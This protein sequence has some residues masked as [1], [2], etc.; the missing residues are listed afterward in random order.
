ME[1]ASIGQILRQEEASAGQHHRLLTAADPNNQPKPQQPTHRGTK[2]PRDGADILAFRGVLCLARSP[3]SLNSNKEKRLVLNP[4]TD[5]TLTIRSPKTSPLNLLQLLQ[6]HVVVVHG[7]GWVAGG[8]VGRGGHGPQSVLL[9]SE[10]ALTN[11]VPP[12]QVLD[13]PLS[14]VGGWREPA[15]TRLKRSARLQGHRD[16]SGE[17]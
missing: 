4:R 5:L 13:H 17:G 12:G 6:V 11:A 2:R 14:V 9:V 10:R 8:A 16:S 15:E 3:V 1:D 7:V